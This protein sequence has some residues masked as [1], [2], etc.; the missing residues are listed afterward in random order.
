SAQSVGTAV[1]ATVQDATQADAANRDVRDHTCLRE[2]GS[3]VTASQNR[4]VVR[5]ARKDNQ[6]TVEVVCADYGRAYTQDDIRGT[7][8]VDIAD[9]LR[10]L[11]PSVH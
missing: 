6:P 4:R 10:R 9:A 11:D 1:Q 3:L 7:G 8:A 2:T 5:R